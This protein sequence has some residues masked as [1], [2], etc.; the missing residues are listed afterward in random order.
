MARLKLD[1]SIGLD[2]KDVEAN[3]PS[4][5]ATRGGQATWVSDPSTS[6]KRLVLGS[7]DDNIVDEE[8]IAETARYAGVKPVFI[9]GPGHNIMLGG[10]WNVAA[11]KIKT[12]L[13]NI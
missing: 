2:I 9:S 1:A 5:N 7:V 13:D 8:G 11:E 4:R 10:R 6:F 3:L 12:W